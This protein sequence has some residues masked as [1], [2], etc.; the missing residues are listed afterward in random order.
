MV[1]SAPIFHKRHFLSC[2]WGTSSFRLRLIASASGKTIHAISET[3]GIKKFYKSWSSNRDSSK[4]LDYYLAFLGKQIEALE[5]SCSSELDRSI[6]VIISGMASSSI[7]MKEL[8]YSSLPLSLV[9]PELN[10][11]H[12]QPSERF[13]RDAYLV[14]GICSSNDV[15][16]GEETELLGLASRLASKNGFYILAGTH[17]K[18]LRVKDNHLTA[19][20]TYM[21][22]ELFDLIASKSILAN[23]VDMRSDPVPGHGFKAGV[24]DAQ[25]EN[26][27]HAL[28]SIRAQDLLH[29]TGKPRNRDYLS[30]LLIGTELSEVVASEPARVILWGNSR[31]QRYYADA[32]E[33]LG[34]DFIH[35]AIKGDED[36][37][38]LGQRIIFNQITN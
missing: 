24:K 4:R 37:T 15:M 9:H 28:F 20:K 36:I 19:F 10:I 7:G 30:G 11:H 16:R 29:N 23:S 27:L 14:S 2:D 25:Q 34:I 3:K 12:V 1:N 21:T 31:L 33:V 22:G 18:H 17:S 6:P 8:P 5:Q 26:L 38:A 32:L 13:S 35:P